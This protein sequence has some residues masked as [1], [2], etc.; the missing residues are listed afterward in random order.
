MVIAAGITAAAA[1]GASAISASS[2]AKSAKEAAEMQQEGT[3]QAVALQERQWLQAR[4]DIAPWREAGL[5]GLGQYEQLARR[6]PPSFAPFRGP[7]ALNAD[8]YRF[9]PPTARDMQRDPG[10]QFRLQQGQQALE[11]SAAARGGLLS[12]GFAR[13]L[14]DYS[15]G[16]ASQEYGNVYQRRMGENQLRYGRDL[17]Q[18]QSAYERALQGYQTNWNAGMQGWQAQM[19]PWAQ[20]AYGGQQANTQTAQ[21][22]ANYAS[23]V[24]DILRA[25]AAN[26]GAAGIA[27]ANAWG[28][29]A[30][31]AASTLGG[32]GMWYGMNRNNPAGTTPRTTEPYDP[33][34]FM[35][36]R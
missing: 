16:M 34:E 24:G 23:Q 17:A 1:I 21:L 4:E 3:D 2:Q 13:N 14:T 35:G 25:N 31:N 6:G 9:R 22:G 36:T 33:F 30:Q 11:R 26:Q 15:Q 27:Q 19:A 12:G 8:A 18:N 28:G 29:F 5:R 20:L 32:L 10:Y 7:G